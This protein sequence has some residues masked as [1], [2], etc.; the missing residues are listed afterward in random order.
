MYLPSEMIILSY[1]WKMQAN[2]LLYIFLIFQ[3]N[4]GGPARGSGTGANRGNP[5]RNTPGANQANR[6]NEGRHIPR[7]FK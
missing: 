3:M 4:R 5:T 7:E 6:G 1:Y 2:I